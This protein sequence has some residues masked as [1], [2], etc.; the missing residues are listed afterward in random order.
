[1]T[2][3]VYNAHHRN[4]PPGAINIGRGSPYG[5]PFR[6]GDL[7]HGRPMTRDDVCNRFECEVLPKLDVSTLRGCDLVCFCKPR[8]CHGDSI[9]RK[10]NA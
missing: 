8:R 1:M 4:A 6:I 7:W 3:A 2:P 10:A 9:L 5:N